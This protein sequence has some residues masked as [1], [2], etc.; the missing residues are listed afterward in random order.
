MSRLDGLKEFEGKLLSFDEEEL[1]IETGRRRHA[2]PYAKV[3][4][5]RLAI[6]F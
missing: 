6:I 1:V 4:S 3:A 2:I 5:A